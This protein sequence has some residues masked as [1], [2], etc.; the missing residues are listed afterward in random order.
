AVALG[1]RP[2][3]FWSC[4]GLLKLGVAVAFINNRISGRPLAHA[5]ATTEASAAIVGDECLEHFEATEGLADITY[6]RLP[7]E[8]ER[9]RPAESVPAWLDD[10][11]Q[12]DIDA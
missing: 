7:E 1:N 11:L 12:Q 8:G 3:F 9:A 10:R 2:M 5:L 6:C 4:F